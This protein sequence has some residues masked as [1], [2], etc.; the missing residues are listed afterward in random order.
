MKTRGR[1]FRTAAIIVLSVGFISAGTAYW[2]GTR[3]AD[4]SG[5]VSM[6]GYDKP[7]RR[8]MAMLYGKQG[9]LIEDMVNSLKQPGTQAFLII[10]VSVIAAAACFYFARLHDADDNIHR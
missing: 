5:D 3:S 9:E 1:Q 6:Q 8:Q 10:A 4:L 2:M 7:Q